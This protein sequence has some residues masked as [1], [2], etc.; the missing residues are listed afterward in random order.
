[1]ES[2]CTNKIGVWEFIREMENVYAWSYGL[3]SKCIIFE[4]TCIL[5]QGTCFTLVIIDGFILL[6]KRVK[7]H[8]T[9][10]L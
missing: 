10:E 3:V 6:N 1:M 8:W 7:S 9:K 4:A 5:Y 2:I